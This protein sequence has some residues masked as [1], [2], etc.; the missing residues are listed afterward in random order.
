MPVAI[1][2]LPEEAEIGEDGLPCANWPSDHLSLV[3]EFEFQGEVWGTA[4]PLSP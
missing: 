2:K 1:L 4:N 3:V